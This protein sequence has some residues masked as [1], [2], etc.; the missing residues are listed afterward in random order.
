MTQPPC[1]P[2][3]PKILNLC[4]RFERA[5]Q[6]SQER[7]PAESRR[8]LELLLVEANQ[9]GLA[10][11]DILWG[12]GCVSDHLRDFPAAIAYC[13]RALEFDAISPSYR[14]SWEIVVG[15]VRE[16]ILDGSRPLDDPEVGALCRLL[17][18]HGAANDAVHARYARLLVAAG[19]LTEAQAILKAILKLSPASPE[20][21]AVL[22]QIAAATNDDDLAGRV[23]AAAM[24]SEQLD[25][26]LALTQPEAQA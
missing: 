22:G 15:R 7:A 20:A 26:P 23:R 10:A 14:R 1:N 21:L 19:N 17:V 11:P 25:L 4:E 12:L 8:E 2:F 5:Q 18:S 6:R 13:R 3:N 9:L 24:R 16:T